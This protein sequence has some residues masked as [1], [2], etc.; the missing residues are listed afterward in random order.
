MQQEPKCNCTTMHDASSSRRELGLRM[1]QKGPLE[2]GKT[3]VKLRDDSAMLV[4]CDWRRCRAKTRYSP[5][6][7]VELRG[8]TRCDLSARI[9][10]GEFVWEKR[11]RRAQYGGRAK[12][13]FYYGRVIAGAK[14]GAW[15]GCVGVGVGVC[16]WRNAADHCPS[17]KR[18]GTCTSRARRGEAQPSPAQPSQQVA[19]P[20]CPAGQPRDWC[21]YEYC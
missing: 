1:D 7:R 9:W 13:P 11:E 19:T 21:C 4:T 3:D 20:P 2:K 6:A 18:T 10:V 5:K 14:A 8:K 17:H 12:Q 16:G 15:C